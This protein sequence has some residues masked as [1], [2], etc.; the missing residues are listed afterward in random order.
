MD[1]KTPNDEYL[2]KARATVLTAKYLFKSLCDKRHK[3]LEV[4][5]KEVMN[6]EG[7]KKAKWSSTLKVNF[8]NQVE[9]LVTA[10]LTAKNPKFIV[11]MRQP[12]AQIADKYYPM[13]KEEPSTPEL[14]EAYKIKQKEREK[15]EEEVGEWGKAIQDYLNFTFNEYD[16]ARKVRLGAKS[17]V[18]YGNVYGSINYKVDYYKTLK[19]GDIEKKKAREYADLDIVSFS[20]ILLDPRFI[21][22]AK[23]Q[24]VILQADFERKAELYALNEGLFNLDKIKEVQQNQSPRPL[25]QQIYSIKISNADG[26]TTEKQTSGL[27]I[28]KY[29][30]YFNPTPE[31]PETE[32]LYEIWLVCE[33]LVVKCKKIA[34]IPVQCA[35]CFEDVE[36]HFSTG[37]VEPILGL[38]REY[39]F[40]MNSSVEYINQS[41]NRSWMWSPL[42]GVDPKQLMNLGPGSMIIAPQGVQQAQQNLVELPYKPIPNEYF[43]AQN[44]TRRDMQSISFTVDTTQSTSSQ[45]FT[46]TATGVRARVYESNV[47]YGDTLKHFEEFLVKLAYEMIDT[48]SENAEDDVVIAQLGA[49]RFKFAKKAVFEEAPLRY[50]IR[51]EVGASSFDSVESRREEALALWTIAKEAK[52]LGEPVDLERV[53]DHIYGTFEGVTSE[54]LKK[55]DFEGLTQELLQ[56][57]GQSVPTTSQDAT[58]AIQRG[59]EPGLSN[60]AELTKAVVQGNIA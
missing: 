37:Y 2:N 44:E 14:M 13:P 6:Y 41:L 43:A 5:Y 21:D 50:Y 60:P 4:L 8:A 19:N 3:E 11:S 7:N 12:I 17:L 55:R 30:G 47:M 46:N 56:K 39:N 20:N 18:R 22:T 28:D 40:K 51:A 35:G 59:G 23:S 25:K 15:F 31:D 54:D 9:S 24:G 32:E 34:R 48:I 10:R 27:Q 57:A 16:Y 36:Q 33:T 26:T 38:Q 53:L 29:Y 42:S 49:D 45:G 52:Q 1:T 58:E